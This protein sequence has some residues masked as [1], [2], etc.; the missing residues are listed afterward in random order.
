MK[1][2]AVAVP[3]LLP[4][5]LAAGCR[6]TRQ[7]EE[8]VGPHVRVLS[9]NVNWGVPRPDLAVEIIR[10]SGA[11]IVCLQETTPEWEDLLRRALG[12][13]YLLAEFRSSSGPRAAGGLAFFSKVPGREVA[14]IPSQT[15]WFDGWIMVFESAIGPI[16]I[17]N[18]HLRPPVS[19]RG[20]WA[21]GYFFTGDDRL[22]E[23]ERFYPRFEPG[24][25]GV[26]AGDFNDGETSPVVEWLESKGMV[27][28]LPQFDRYTA[29]WEW[30]SSLITLRRRMDHVLYSP[31]LDCLSARVLRAGASDHFPVEAVFSMKA[32]RTGK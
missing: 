5:L 19:D 24:L 32:G 15:G 18:V 17:L 28:A 20:S 6:S 14:Y 12:R 30:Q 13:D 9:Y 27:N 23:M 2:A 4:L 10:D 22:R 16:Q 8:P 25:P 31:E 1:R 3:A 7:P 21:S 29:T 26:V 11:D